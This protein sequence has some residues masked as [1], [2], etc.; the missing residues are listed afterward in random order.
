M[1]GPGSGKDTQCERL[2]D[3]Y[4]CAN[5]S[6]VDLLR[7]AVTSNSSQGVMI[8]NMIRSGQIVPTQVTL[9]LLKEA[10]RGATG[11]FVVQERAPLASPNPL[12]YHAARL[13]D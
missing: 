7:T 9:D 8:S 5:L 1:G 3:K 6:A 11:P 2:A 13:A 4:G 12:P 10:M